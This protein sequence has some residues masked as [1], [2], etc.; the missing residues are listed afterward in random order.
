MVQSMPAKNKKTYRIIMAIFLS[1]GL[2]LVQATV[3]SQVYAQA[4]ST[5]TVTET[6]FRIGGGG[7]ANYCGPDLARLYMDLQYKVIQATR[8]VKG[9]VCGRLVIIQDVKS[10]KEYIGLMPCNRPDG[11]YIFNMRP[12]QLLNYY[13]LVDVKIKK[14]KVIVSKDFGEVSRYI[15]QFSTFYRI[16]DCYSCGY[17]PAP[18]SSPPFVFPS[19][20]STNSAS[21]FTSDIKGTLIALSGFQGFVTSSKYE[22]GSAYSTGVPSES[23]DKEVDLTATPAPKQETLVP[24]A[25]ISENSPAP[26]LTMTP[27]PEPGVSQTQGV[28]TANNE[29]PPSVEPISFLNYSRYTLLL[30]PLIILVIILLRANMS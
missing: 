11:P 3:W 5:P 26:Y 19:P 18:I 21:A 1:L 22:Y 7:G 25:S 20:T 23:L 13:M 30:V 16:D 8:R 2:L 28:I 29:K 14:G 12:N 17:L 9:A 15:T 10:K 24:P 27:T 6:L 4:T